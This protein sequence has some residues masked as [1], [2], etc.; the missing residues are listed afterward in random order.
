MLKLN[1]YSHN[2]CLVLVV[3]NNVCI[4]KV[5]Q[6]I[7]SIKMYAKKWGEK[8]FVKQQNIKTNSKYAILKWWNEIK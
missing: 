4:C 1:S 8:K 7:A 2:S 6:S 5:W 3:V